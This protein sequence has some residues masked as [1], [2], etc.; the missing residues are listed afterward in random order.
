MKSTMHTFKNIGKVRKVP[1]TSVNCLFCINKIYRA[2]T[3]PKSVQILKSLQ[4]R[5]S[6]DF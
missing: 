3:C 4:Y 1:I 2:L 5:N 6:T